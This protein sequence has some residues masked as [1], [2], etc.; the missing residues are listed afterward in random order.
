MFSASYLSS[1]HN[2]IIIIIH[3]Y[4]MDLDYN[5]IHD[6]NMNLDYN[7]IQYDSI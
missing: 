6:Y 2:R 3:D 4:N 1:V 7:M 5:M